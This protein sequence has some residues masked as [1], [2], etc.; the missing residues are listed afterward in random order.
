M[1]QY[2]AEHHPIK[3]Y[4]VESL[5]FEDFTEVKSF[6]RILDILVASSQPSAPFE[7]TALVTHTSKPR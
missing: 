4:W 5:C 6:A 7:E 1:S 2:C 3:R